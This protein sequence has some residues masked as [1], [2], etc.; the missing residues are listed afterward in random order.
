MNFS[1]SY[2]YRLYLIFS[3]LLVPFPLFFSHYCFYI[4]LHRSLVSPANPFS[5]LVIFVSFTL[6]SFVMPFSHFI[7]TFFCRS[8]SCCLFFLF[9]YSLG[10][11]LKQSPMNFSLIL[12]L[13]LH[14][15]LL[16]HPA[17]IHLPFF[18][19]TNRKTM[20]TRRPCR[21]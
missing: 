10:E 9:T 12:L 13:F 19:C 1:N 18:F 3:N 5:V 8:L 6:M 2:R 21:L 17:Y 20:C 16:P 4:L 14:P 7:P 15:V 11:L